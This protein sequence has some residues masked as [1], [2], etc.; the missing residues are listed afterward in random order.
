MAYPP[1]EIMSFAFITKLDEAGGGVTYVGLAAPGGVTSTAVWQIRKLTE[2]GA[3]LTI[4]YASGSANF[5]YVWDDRA[6]LSYS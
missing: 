1:H 5:A 3:I 4:Q 2:S 6:S